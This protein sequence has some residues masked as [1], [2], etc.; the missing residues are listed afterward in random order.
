ML[1]SDALLKELLETFELEAREHL[2]ELSTLLISLEREPEAAERVRLLEA[3]FRRVHTLKGAAH[4][5]NLPDVA[6]ACQRLEDVLADL[7]RGD[8]PLGL[9]QF[10]SLHVSINELGERVTFYHPAA[11]A[12][13]AS[14]APHELPVAAAVP[15]DPAPVGVE[16]RAPLPAREAAAHHG[17]P[18]T[19]SAPHRAPQRKAAEARPPAARPYGDETVRVSARLLEELLLQSEELVSA[20][21]SASA[22][23]EELAAAAGELALRQGERSRALET[24]RRIVKG[25]SGREAA[26]AAMLEQSCQTERHLE[27]RLRLLEKSADKHLRSLQAMLDPLLE[28]MKKLQLLPCSTLCD[29]FAKLV[30]DLS[31]ELGKE[32]E[33]SC[34]GGE[35]EIDRRILA[36]LKEPLLHLVRNTVDHGIEEPQ[37]RLAAGKP[38]RGAIGL[39][40]RLQD[41]NRAEL[42]LEDDGRGIDLARIKAAAKRLEA[43]PAELLERM[44]DHEALQLIFESGLST[45]SSVGNVSGRGLGL[46]IVRHSLERLGGHV[47]VS[48]T[49]GAGTVFRLAFPLS[50]ARIR[51]LLVQVAG[52][53][54]VIPAT[55]VELSSRVAPA[56]VKRVENRDTVLVNGE[57]VALVALARILELKRGA[58]AAEDNLCFVLL[59]AGEKRIA[60]AVDQVLGVQ[61][62]LVKPLGRQLS[63]VRNV[64]GG[65]VLG[66]GRVVPVLNVADLFRSAL[67]V[68][69]PPVSPPSHAPQARRVSVLVAEDSITSRTL[70]KNI[71]ESAGYEVRT[72]VDGADALSQLKSQACDVVI[73]DIEMPRM[74]GF[75]LTEAIRADG[76]LSTLPVILVTGLES[77]SDRERGIDAGASAYL[78]KSSFDQGNLIEVIQKLS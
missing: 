59:H 42:I 63:R 24:A 48:S 12:V 52:R 20:K 17:A 51:G 41:A 25:A 15:P 23:H 11:T 1:D 65:T 75:Q 46:A 21:L 71:L 53:D 30:R 68:E 44:Q 36:E 72:A 2:G 37:Q 67:S 50:F 73:S 29:P 6:L 31:R 39:E 56:E 58:Q 13:P 61:E 69:A 35:L 14:S 66:N 10:D 78:V 70:L 33:F 9:E 55:N 3:I 57:V 32:A 47:T 43:A 76:R 62:I 38:A 34:L 19:S 60:F 77:R 45:S 22:L 74:D 64:S 18:P 54:C 8:L 5:V 16:P 28:E 26:L 49:P 4:A 7:K 27:G 40:I